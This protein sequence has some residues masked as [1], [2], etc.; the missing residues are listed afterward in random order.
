ME[1]PNASRLTHSNPPVIATENLQILNDGENGGNEEESEPDNNTNDSSS[2]HPSST[3]TPRLID[4]RST[5]AMINSLMPLS[6]RDQQGTPLSATCREN[7][8]TRSV[9]T[10]RSL[11]VS[12]ENIEYEWLDDQTFTSIPA[13]FGGLVLRTNNVDNFLVVKLCLFYLMEFLIGT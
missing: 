7:N 5:S 1:V 3:A 8:S 4:V 11:D 10:R 12:V 6:V 2:F 9:P 13:L